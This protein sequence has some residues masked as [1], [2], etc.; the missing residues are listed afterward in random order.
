MLNILNFILTCTASI[1]VLEYNIFR[2][3]SEPHIVNSKLIIF[4][5]KT[6][7]IIF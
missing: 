3:L 1:N 4:T 5:F 2:V 7:I 6:E